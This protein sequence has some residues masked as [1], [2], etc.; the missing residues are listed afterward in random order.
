MLDTIV[1]NVKLHVEGELEKG[2]RYLLKGCTPDSCDI[3]RYNVYL[4]KPKMGDKITFLN[5]G[6]YTYTTD[7]CALDK[8]KIEIVEK[9]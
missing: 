1:A 4:D 9:F 7:F 8:I 2:D 6:A 3:L 5:C